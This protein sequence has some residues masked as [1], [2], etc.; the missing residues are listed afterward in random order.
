MYF[1]ALSASVTDTWSALLENHSL[2]HE[3]VKGMLRF[4]DPS[5]RQTNPI[6]IFRSQDDSFLTRLLS[7]ADLF[8]AFSLGVLLTTSIAGTSPLFWQIFHRL[9]A[10]SGLPVLG[11]AVGTLANLDRSGG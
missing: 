9:P 10:H 6:F 11:I 8:A 3:G 7:K 1:L 5:W 4:D 2:I